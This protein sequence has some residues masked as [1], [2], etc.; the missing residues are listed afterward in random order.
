[1]GKLSLHRR[2]RLDLVGRLVLTQTLEC[3]LADIAVG[4]EAGEFDLRDELW[5]EPMH[6]AG[7]LRRV[8]AAERTLP[9]PRRLQERHDAPD[10]VGAKSRAD[11]ADKG[12]LIA[13]M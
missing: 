1:L 4:G 8:L 6:V 3:G 11:P 5:P 12:Q 9:G 7:L 13:A 10:S 2:F